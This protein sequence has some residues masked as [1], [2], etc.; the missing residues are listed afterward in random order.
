VS[1]QILTDGE[2]G[3]LGLAFDPG[4]ASNGFFYVDLINKSGDA[5]IRR[6][7]VSGN[8]NV[9]DPASVTPIIAID[10]TAASNHKAGWLGFGPDGYLYNSNGDGG[11]PPT[12]AQD[13]NSLLGKDSAHRR[14]RRR[15]PRRPDAQLRGARRQPVRGHCRSQ[16]NIYAL[17]LRNPWRPSFD[18]ALGDFYI[19][20]VGN[21]QYEE[22]DI[23]QKGANYGWPVFEGPVVLLC[24]TPT[25]GSAVPPI[26][27]YDHSVGHSITGG[28]V[29]RGEGEALQGQYF[30]ADFVQAKVFTLRFDGSTWVATD[31]T[32]QIQTDAGFVTNPT[33]FGEDARGNL[34]LT[35]FDGEVF[36]LTPVVDSADQGDVLHGL[37]GD[38]ML[39]G[40]SGND[41][42]DGGP[43]ADIM[44]GGAC[45]D[46]ADYSSSAAGVTVNLA[47]GVGTGGDAQ[48][49]VLGGIENIIGSAQADA[50]MGGSGANMLAGGPGNDAY[51]VDNA[52]DQ[53]I[54]NAAEGLDTIYSTT[55]FRLPANVETLVLQG[56]ADLQAYG[57]G[58]S[59]SVYG[60]AGINLVDG[61]AGPDAMFGGARQ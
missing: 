23:G 51:F 36:R 52:G 25:L 39:F 59:N 40:G 38:D 60:N 1:G 54:E 28:Y 6:Y 47:S 12:S 22:I 30:F 5:E 4:F 26:Y 50:L 46:T 24:G 43:G 33:S 27:Y 34:Y 18:L 32:S 44:L 37:A 16:R 48:G 13:I 8:P 31:R 42:L 21:T 17:G 57:N 56:G 9:A 7:H 41:T 55:H 53:V 10:Q 49:D 61:G 14:A 11:V 19:A 35:D 58:L 29:Y 2:R 20:D 45:S 3:L 15:L